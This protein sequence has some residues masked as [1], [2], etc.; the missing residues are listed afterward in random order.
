MKQRNL[1]LVNGNITINLF[2]LSI[3]IILTSLMTILYNLIDIK[4][5]SYYLGDD[6]VASATA[7]TFFVNLSYSLL[8]IPKNSVQIY[9]AQSIGARRKNSAKKYSRVSLIIAFIFSVI[10][11]I[12]VYF[13]ASFLIKLVGIKSEVFLIPA[14]DF[15][16]LTSFSFVFLFIS[17]TISSIINGEGDTLGPFMFL[18]FGLVL[19]I[20][21]DYLFLAI[22]KT[23]LN[24]IAYST[25]LA[26]FFT[27]LM[28]II[29]LKRKNSI[30]RN[31]K[32]LKIDDIKY[33]RNIIKLGLPT[34]ISQA[35]FT[36]ISILIAQMIANVDESMLAVQRL[37]IQ[38]EAFSWNV[39][40]GFGTAVATF[41]AYNFG[42]AKYE[43]IFKIYKI[44]I[45][46]VSTICLILTSLFIFYARDLYSAFFKNERLIKE[47]INYLTIIGLAQVPQGIES[48][49]TGA[50]NG[51]RKTKEPNLISIL[52]TSIRIPMVKILLP[53]FGI[54][55]IWWTIHIT[56]L[57]KGII[58][59]I[60]F[61]LSWK[62]YLEYVKIS[63]INQNER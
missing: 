53:I 39:A 7:A 25:I 13:F 12:L 20:F 33:Y 36:L 31:M 19:N 2:K 11:S 8:F 38:F 40:A 28:L 27:M 29:Y 50:F 54:V 55:G 5:I 17:Q 51:I 26:Q 1:D 43:R 35:L 41:I 15:L 49:T 59:M 57:L 24:G 32:I 48:I 58:S 37:G 44:S 9:V 30:F 18:S 45:I 4:F 10:Y 46:T 62:N 34:G 47:G 6:A 14:V 3:P 21:F 63:I 23:N 61:I 60:W 42:A 52:G 16:K 22:F 56:M